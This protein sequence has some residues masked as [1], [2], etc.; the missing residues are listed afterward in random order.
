MTLFE[1][2]DE[3][4]EKDCAT[5][6]RCVTTEQPPS[7]T[8]NCIP[9]FKHEPPIVGRHNCGVILV[10]HEIFHNIQNMEDFYSALGYDE[11][12]RNMQLSGEEFIWD[13]YTRDHSK[14][15]KHC[16]QVQIQIYLHQSCSKFRELYGHEYEAMI[17]NCRSKFIDGDDKH[18]ANCPMQ[19]NRD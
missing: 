9:S 13:R 19:P 2:R 7:H 1:K 12:A 3:N 15:S 8:S 14:M 16:L 18:C 6:T 17:R 4:A 10:G 5:V 11:A